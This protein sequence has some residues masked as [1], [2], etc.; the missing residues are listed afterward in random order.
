MT[1]LDRF[2]IAVVMEYEFQAAV[3]KNKVRDR[4][5]TDST[6]ANGISLLNPFA[7]TRQH[8]R[9]GAERINV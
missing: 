1:T 5:K 3:K 2:L 9:S 4:L 7:E 8:Q 6:C